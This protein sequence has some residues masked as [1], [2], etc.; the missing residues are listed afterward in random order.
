MTVTPDQHQHQREVDVAIRGLVNDVL[1]QG[2]Q[3]VELVANA[4]RQR[5]D[6]VPA[7][8]RPGDPGK[9][10]RIDTLVTHG[11]EV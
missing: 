6:P 4:R 3:L 10:R 1:R 9:F 11:H 7:P 2:F 8:A 5:I